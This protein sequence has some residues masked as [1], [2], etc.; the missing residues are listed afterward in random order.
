MATWFVSERNLRPLQRHAGSKARDDVDDILVAMNIH[1]LF[2]DCPLKERSGDAALLKKLAGHTAARDAWR[3]VL[4]KLSPGDNVIIQFP[5]F[6]HSVFLSGVLKNAKK[7]GIR[8]VYLVHDL[9]CLRYDDV[10]DM[11]LRF[12]RIQREEMGLLR[13]A[14]A[15]I[16]HN[17]RM[18]SILEQRELVVD[19]Y[20]E[21]LDV[22]DYLVSGGNECW[23]DIARE[24]PVVIA[25]NLDPQKT[26]FV[27]HL[28]SNVSFNLY[29]P[30]YDDAFA[31]K[32]G[33]T[34]QGSY[35]ADEL[36]C[37]LRGSFGLVWDGDSIE[38]CSG[39]FGQYLRINNPHKTSL[40]LASGMPVIVW[41]QAAIADFVR[42]ENVGLC[43]SNLNNLHDVVNNI[44]AADYEEMA[45]RARNV[46]KKLREGHFT[47]KAVTRVLDAASHR[48]LSI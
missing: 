40:Y 4:E 21:P 33:T 37:K 30:N 13:L 8:L 42:R 6:N 45:V 24:G 18:K 44:D 47:R 29:G 41:S 39:A 3:K 7:R 22:F 34:Y 23:A 35:P 26:G 46:G 14:D 16:V 20:V 32:D 43:I 12:W 15:V 10:G 9:D 28:P 5:P 17:K 19:S 36:V 27:Y 31:L 1:E 2:F 11:R 48:D 25:G 38:T